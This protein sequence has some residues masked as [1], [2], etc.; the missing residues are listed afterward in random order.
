M[1]GLPLNRYQLLAIQHITLLSRQ[2]VSRN[3]VNDTRG[4]ISFQSVFFSAF[5]EDWSAFCLDICKQPL[6]GKIWLNSLISE[7]IR[8]FPVPV[9]QNLKPNIKILTYCICFFIIIIHLQK[10]FTYPFKKYLLEQN[11]ISKLLQVQNNRAFTIC[12]CIIAVETWTLTYHL[13]S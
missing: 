13:S 6:L 3:M 10:Y 8:I 9:Q 5:S 1:Y 2:V 12:Y 4:L 7:H 11:S